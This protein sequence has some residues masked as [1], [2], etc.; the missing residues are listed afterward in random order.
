MLGDDVG[1]RSAGDDTGI[2]R[3]AHAQLGE[4][5]DGLEEAREFQDRRV[6]AGEIDPAVR[7]DASD[8]QAIVADT[9]ARGLAGEALRGLQHQ[10][11]LRC[12]R[13]PLGDGAETGLPTSSSGFK[14]SVMGRLTPSC[15]SARMAARAI[16]TPDFMSRTPGP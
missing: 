14:S 12:E 11:S 6:A 5:G 1:A 3:E 9:L 4:A 13:E 2:H 16:A 7:C 15:E 8:V 10:N